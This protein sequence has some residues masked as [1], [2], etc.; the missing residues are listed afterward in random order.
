MG[1]DDQYVTYSNLFYQNP[2]ESLFQ[3]EGN[4]ALYNNLFVNNYGDAIRIQP[5]NDVPRHINIFYNTV[6]ASGKGISIINKTDSPSYPQK[7]A[8]N[9][10]FALDTFPQKL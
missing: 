5:H 6:I 7:V 8:G 9:A 10:I 4:I 2:N 3:G 1:I